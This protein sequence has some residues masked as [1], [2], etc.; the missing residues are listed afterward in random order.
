MLIVNEHEERGGVGGEE[1]GSA[2]PLYYGKTETLSEKEPRPCNAVLGNESKA[3]GR[4]SKHVINFVCLE[5]HLLKIHVRRV[6]YQDTTGVLHRYHFSRIAFLKTDIC[7]AHLT[8]F[9]FL[10]SLSSFSACN[11]RRER[12]CLQISNTVLVQKQT[13]R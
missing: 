2:C 1:G 7:E 4:H 6:L 10:G 3:K 9:R 11:V 8:H 5:F 13:G 12:R